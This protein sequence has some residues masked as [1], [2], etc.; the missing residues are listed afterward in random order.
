M[1][2]QMSVV[3]FPT[4]G[5]RTLRGALLGAAA[6]TAVGGVA[7]GNRAFSASAAIVGVTQP[8]AGPASVGDVLDR[9]KTSVVS[10]K[11]KLADGG[12]ADAD[13]DTPALPHFAPGGPFDRFFKQFGFPDDQ[14]GAAPLHRRPHRQS[15]VDGSR[16]FISAGPYNVHH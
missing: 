6:V 9:V 15:L 11:V 1:E 3:P 10:V 4:L 14:D 16:L 7:I 12:D 13:S 5:K 8:S 2:N